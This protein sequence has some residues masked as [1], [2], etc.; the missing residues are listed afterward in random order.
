M[1]QQSP[2]IAVIY[3][4]VVKDG[5]DEP[6]KE[7]WADLTDEIHKQSCSHGSVLHYA[8]DNE[9]IAYARWPSMDVLDASN[10]TGARAE[11]ARSKMGESCSKIE[12]LYKMEVAED[13]LRAY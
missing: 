11:A 7:G 3:R 6:F 8:G 1:T 5:L 4:F 9:Y 13:M 12:T 2:K 10:V